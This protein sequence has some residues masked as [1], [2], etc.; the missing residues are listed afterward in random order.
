MSA[1][2]QVTRTEQGA[3]LSDDKQTI[4]VEFC[5]PGIVRVRKFPGGVPPTKL[6]IR[7]EFFKDDWTPTGLSFQEDVESVSL[8]SELLTVSV[9]LAD[10]TISVLDAAGEELLKETM[11]AV[12]GPEPGFEARFELPAQR[13]FFGTGDQNRERV[14]HRGHSADLWVRNVTSYMP[15][16]FFMTNDGFGLLVNTTRQTLLD[17]GASSEDWFGFSA[18]GDSLDYYFLYGP[19]PKEVITRY[20]EVTGKPFMPPKWAFGLFFICRTQADA[21]ELMDDCYSFRRERIPCD[22]ISLE[23]GWMETNYDFSVEKKW[24]PERFPIAS[25]SEQA[26]DGFLHAIRRM[27]Y[28]FGLWL[29][30]D[31][32]FTHEEERRL[33]VSVETAEDESKAEHDLFKD[34]QLGHG[35]RLDKWTRPE[36]PWF[37]HLKKFV[38]QGAEFFKQDAGSTVFHHP[39]RLWGN[40]L[41]D[42]DMHNLIPLFYARQMYE[43]LRD[44]TGRRPFVF[45][46]LGWAGIQAHAAT[47]AGDTGGEHNSAMASLN[48]SMSGHGMTT[49][50]MHV[51]TPAGIHFGFLQPWSMINSFY[52]WYHPWYLGDEM[53]PIF[54][55][56][57][58]LRYR[59][60]P[61]LYSCAWE[62]HTTGVPIL[63]AMPLEFPD[64]PQTHDLQRQYM[65]GPAI[66]VGMFTDRIYLPEGDWHDFWSGERVS[67]GQWYEPAVPA[68]RGGPLMVRPGAIVPMNGRE[69]EYVGQE[70]DDELTVHVYPGPATA[71]ELY[72]D[73]GTGHEFE[74]GKRRITRMAQESTDEHTHIEIAAAEGDFEGAVQSRHLQFVVHDIPYPSDVVVNGENVSPGGEDVTPAWQWQK[75]SSKLTI[76]LGECSVGEPVSVD[77]SY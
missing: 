55:W 43:G 29:C 16:P 56:Y 39:D 67:G 57:A 14:E 63:R 52:C 70:P 37:E 18:A 54:I 17:L 53:K 72:E 73:D 22:A 15:I 19:S 66:L 7:Y 3:L 41:T 1:K 24:H 35:M 76:D 77:I 62:A 28:K 25:W 60:I 46:C 6:L 5:T 64:D 44:H 58:R 40:G 69:I 49:C 47:W 31:Y 27:G 45:Y 59:L 74:D 71:F 38:D 21:R 11:P 33:G 8:S 20:T 13:R 36:E 12:S 32:D 65:L 4:A 30:C 26:Q 48:L 34:E 51:F 75:T 9:A 2:Y 61:Y 68:N 50:D 23:P 42:A 10:G